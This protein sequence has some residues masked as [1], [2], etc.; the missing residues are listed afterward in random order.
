MDGNYQDYYFNPLLVDSGIESGETEEAQGVREDQ[1]YVTAKADDGKYYTVLKQ[2][3]QESLK[4]NEEALTSRH[5]LKDKLKKFTV[6]GKEY[7]GTETGDP[8]TSNTKKYYDAI[9]WEVDKDYKTYKKTAGTTELARPFED[10]AIL[11]DRFG[12][13]SEYTDITEMSDVDY[14]YEFGQDI[15]LK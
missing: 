12:D 8:I 4:K 15:P 7:Y 11:G 13:L 9:R 3:L 2:D 10:V 14:M 6:D 5:P 1:V